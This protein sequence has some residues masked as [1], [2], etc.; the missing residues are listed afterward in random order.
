MKEKRKE[1]KRKEKKRKE[2]KRKEK[3]RK[4]KKSSMKVKQLSGE[5]IFKGGNPNNREK[6]KIRQ[7][8]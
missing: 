7:Y 8:Y 2:K 4:E 3:K 6:L 5:S 1:K